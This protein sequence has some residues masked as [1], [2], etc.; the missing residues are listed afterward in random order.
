MMPFLGPLLA[1]GGSFL[2]SSSAKK[3]AAA[4]N[5]A[6]AAL[7]K[8]QNDFN[9]RLFRESR[10]SEG[11]AVL[12]LFFGDA[13]QNLADDLI[14]RFN[15]SDE[16]FGTTEE[17]IAR[18]QGFIDAQSGAIAG[19]NRLISSVQDG[20]LLADRQAALDPL[21]Q[22]RTDRIPLLR[23][24]FE[25]LTANI[26]DVSD[27]RLNLGD[28]FDARSSTIRADARGLQGPALQRFLEEQKRLVGDTGDARLNLALA[29]KAGISLAGQQAQNRI[30]AQAVQDGFLSGGTFQNN[31]ILRSLIGENQA[32]VQAIEGAKLINAGNRE[33]INIESV[34]LLEADNALTNAQEAFD[35]GLINADQLQ[36]AKLQ[37]AIDKVNLIPSNVDLEGNEL[38]GQNALNRQQ[39]FEDDLA[40]RFATL[41]TPFERAEN[42]INLSKLPQQNLFSDQLNLQNALNFF[43]IG[44]QQAPQAVNQPAAVVAPGFGAGLGQIAAGAG[45]GLIEKAIKGGSGTTPTI[46]GTT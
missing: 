23:R 13:E 12:P 22:V 26:G 30:Q 15:Q 44:P 18:D 40:T 38:L 16:L 36:Q 19:G 31:A 4:Q 10:G 9:Y 46:A 42:Q 29:Q 11:N 20:S 37:A 27:A 24:A 8:Q 3:T 21:L 7:A 35:A 41:N 2:A 45:A 25:E 43:R 34:G 17:R 5:E 28:V 6:N 33:A 1:I 32:A 39:L 14:S